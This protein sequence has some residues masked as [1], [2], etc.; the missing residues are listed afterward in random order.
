M[1]EN[2]SG[3]LP[4]WFWIIGGVALLWN[5]MGVA[6]YLSFTMMAPDELAKLPQDQQALVTDYPAWATAAFALAVFAGVAGAVLLLLR[7]SLA[8]P[9]FGASLVAIIVQ[10]T[11]WLG[12]SGAMAVYGASSLLMPSLVI[13][14]GAFLLWFSMQSKSKGWLR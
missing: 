7:K 9:V 5:L 2:Q 8:A 10:M 14:A 12:L 3:K 4:I 11:W 1:S 6:S 13:I